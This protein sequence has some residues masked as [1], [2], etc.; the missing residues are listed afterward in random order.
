[1]ELEGN[2]LFNF[3]PAIPKHGQ[4]VKLDLPPGPLGWTGNTYYKDDK[5]NYRFVYS[6]KDA[7]AGR[8][9]NTIILEFP[10]AALTKSPATDRIVNAWGESWVL[11][12][13]NKVETIPDDRP[14]VKQ[15]IWLEHPWVI[16]GMAALFGLFLVL[17]SWGAGAGGVLWRI[18]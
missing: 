5:G 17:R 14:R 18:V 6:G 15:P 4:G 10:L 9:V 12:A 8:N 11:K 2:T 7:Q 3:N 13:A 16:P 1:I